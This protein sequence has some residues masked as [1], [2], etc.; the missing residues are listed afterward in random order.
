MRAPLNEDNLNEIECQKPIQNKFRLSAQLI[1][2]QIN[3]RH[4]VS[5]YDERKHKREMW[6]SITYVNNAKIHWTDP[7]RMQIYRRR[8]IF[9]V[10]FSRYRLRRINVPGDFTRCR[11]VSVNS[12]WDYLSRYWW[13][14]RR[15]STPK[16]VI[17]S[18]LRDPQPFRRPSQ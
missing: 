9:L 10:N 15:S 3:F 16:L 13:G 7:A 6:L 18:T 17:R 8:N 11:R 5:I 12:V 4:N 2:K 14:G 1:E